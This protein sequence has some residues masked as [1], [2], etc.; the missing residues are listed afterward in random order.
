MAVPVAIY[1]AIP[2]SL[3]LP[4]SFSAAAAY[5]YPNFLSMNQPLPL[6]APLFCRFHFTNIYSYQCFLKTKIKIEF[7]ILSLYFLTFKIE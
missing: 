1:Q 2:P 7:M 3:V 5:T 6:L 4:A